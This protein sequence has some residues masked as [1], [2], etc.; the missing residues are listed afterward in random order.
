MYIEE[1]LRLISS[2]DM[3]STEKV[4]EQYFNFTSR[5]T[6]QTR[7]VKSGKSNIDAKSSRKATLVV[8]RLIDGKGFHTGTEVDIKSS[9]LAK[10][11]QEINPD[12]EGVSLT[13]I[14]LKAPAEFFYHNWS[15]LQQRLKKEEEAHPRDED[16]IN[17]LNVVLRFIVE[18]YET[19]NQN[20]KSLL[21]AGEITWDLLWALFP[22]NVL[23]YRYHELTRQSQILRFRTMKKRK[24]I[25][26]DTIQWEFSCDV[27]VDDGEK[28]GVAKEPIK[29]TIPEF[30]GVWSIGDL[31]LFPL[32]R[33]KDADNLRREALERGKRYVAIKETRLAQTSGFAM[34]E[35]RSQDYYQPYLYKFATHG[36]AIVDASAFRHFNPNVSFI[37]RVHRSLSRGL[38]MGGLTNFDWNK[39][40]F[41]KL[42]MDEQLKTLVR[43]LV[44]QHSSDQS[45]GFDDIIS[46]KGKGLIGMFSGPPGSGKTLTAEAVAEITQRPLYSVS[47]GELGVDPKSVDENLTKILELAHR[48][49]A[50]L[51]LDEADVFLQQ[52]DT[53]DVNRNALVS[54]F[55]RQLEYFQGILILT[56]N[57]IA[58]CDPAFASRIHISLNYPD[59]DAGA[60]ETVWRNFLGKAKGAQGDVVVDLS[61]PEIR[62][63]AKV[64]LN[65]RQIKN[66]VGSARALAKETRQKITFSGINVVL[67]VLR[68]GPAIAEVETLI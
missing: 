53:H 4:T 2:E 34:F 38:A 24:I 11:L 67:G 59:L 52:R 44:Q 20:V 23:V 25:Q 56:T 14:P 32:D 68:A 47:A 18:D 28:F 10:V 43:S 33:H 63:L 49:N 48:W 37:P 16:L 9:R 66:V 41:E 29:L 50:V 54:I 58:H 5:Q 35:D 1:A 40:A 7:L 61:D 15:A 3:I 55:L 12:V 19:L 8:R 26:N 39:E 17:E 22:P 57:R 36:R 45:G 31:L 30:K 27:I 13:A 21:S 64:E 62:D 51:L 42:V 65:G 60:R 46:G 6:S